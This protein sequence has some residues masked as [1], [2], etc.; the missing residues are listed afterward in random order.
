[1]ARNSSAVTKV[2]VE[3]AIN[4][5]ELLWGASKDCWLDQFNYAATDI[6]RKVYAVY[7][8]KDGHCFTNT[9]GEEDTES[10]VKSVSQSAFANVDWVQKVVYCVHCLPDTRSNCRATVGSRCKEK[11]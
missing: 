9:P 8:V 6:E 1:M 7:R 2:E 3:A 5:E 11:G 10:A 4:E